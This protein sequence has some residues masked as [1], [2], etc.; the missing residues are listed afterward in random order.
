MSGYFFKGL[1]R[2]LHQLRT[3]FMHRR[4]CAAHQINLPSLPAHYSCILQEL[5]E[6]GASVTSLERLLV[7]GTAEALAGLDR[8]F[9]QTDFLQAK[10]GEY[11]VHATSSM[12]EVESDVVRW[13]LDLGLLALVEHYIGLPIAYRGLTARRECA[14]GKMSG[15]RMWHR[16]DEDVAILKIIIYVND[17]DLE[18]GPFEFIPS[19]NAPPEWR[20]PMV[21]S[22]RVRDVDMSGLVPSYFWT[23]C[24][25]PRGTVVI[26]DPSRVYH[27]GVVPKVRDR[28]AAF[29]CF[30]SS[31]PL[32]PQWCQPLFNRE[33][34][35]A[36][37]LI[38]QRQ[39]AALKYK[40]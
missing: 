29:F 32:N 18:T 40:Y 14:D 39:L 35:I 17:V 25:G 15:T 7:P 28:K 9:A 13:G 38:E 6:N 26:V 36:D 11:A 24:V 1:R 30:N 21:E 4:K 19:T 2:H 31:E 10:V 37:N 23:P 5:R 34:F 22:S 12:I 8:I 16:D 3:Q 33:S 27:R 20:V